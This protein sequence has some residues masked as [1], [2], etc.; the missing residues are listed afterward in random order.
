MVDNDVA[1]GLRFTD[2]GRSFEREEE[3]RLVSVGV[4]IGSS[5]C[6]LVF[7]RLLLKRLENRYV[8]SDREVIYESEVLLTPYL[9]DF[10]ID[11]TLLGEFIEGQYAA[12]GLAP[13]DIDTGVLILTGVATRR[14]NSRS[15]G[16]LFA[17]QAGK[18]VAVSAGDALEAR[19][20]AYG[21][22]AIRRSREERQLRVMNVDVGGGT[23]KITVCLNGE[24]VDFTVMDVGARLITFDG[25]RRVARIEDAGHRFASYAG[26]CLSVGDILSDDAIG[27]IIDH[28]VEKLFEA[29]SASPVPKETKAL[30]R[31]PPLREAPP[32]DRLAFSGGVAE[33]LY[34]RETRDYGDLGARFAAAIESRLQDWPTKL[35]VPTESIR[36]TVVGASQYAVQVSGNTVFVSPLSVL[37]VRNV[38]VLTPNIDLA[39]EE[40]DIESIAAAVASAIRRDAG[41][42]HRSVALFYRWKGAATYSRIDAFCAAIAKGHSSVQREGL[43]LILVTHGDVGGLIGMHFHERG[44]TATAVISIDGIELR[45][46][47]FIDIGEFLETSGAVPVVIKSLVFPRA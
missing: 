14:E 45:E 34:G 27:M 31:L 4:D 1:L 28:M 30:L 3:L 25:E 6:H 35:G 12:A 37:P 18:F 5:T 19:L 22:G 15:V 17:G 41:D 8:V 26:I 7:S 33:Y 29:M 47:E 42:D 21:S 32:P 38:P 24:I 44:G 43:P 10:A 13:E 23:T 40:L 39:P 16:D 20:A 11:A 36:A 46:F 2:T 9:D